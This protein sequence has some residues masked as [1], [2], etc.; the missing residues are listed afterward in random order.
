MGF[1]WVR[2]VVGCAL[3]MV[4]VQ[5]MIGLTVQAQVVD[6]G[7]GSLVQA[8]GE[9]TGGIGSLLVRFRPG[10]RPVTS[11]GD[12]RGSAFIPARMK[13]SLRVGKRLGFGIWRID[14]SRPVSVRE[15]KRISVFMMKDRNV[16]LAE[17]DYPVSISSRSTS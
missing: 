1:G 16:V 9:V 2:I 7:S 12:V 14:L 4:L 13:V 8:S 11:A 5:S 3:A 6:R 15:A 10:L 17:P